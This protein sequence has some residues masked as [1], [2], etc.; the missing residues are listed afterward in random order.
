MGLI[1]HAVSAPAFIALSDLHRELVDGD[2][3]YFDYRMQVQN[4]EVALEDF[5]DADHP[6]N[7]D[8][9]LNA[10]GTAPDVDNAAFGPYQQPRLRLIEIPNYNTSESFDVPAYVVAHET[11]HQC[12]RQRVVPAP[13]FAFRLIAETMAQYSA[14]LTIERLHRPA[15]VRTLLRKEL[16]R[17]LH[18]RRGAG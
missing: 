11:G 18:S 17:Y 7:L 5:Y 1:Q 9:Q 8:D 4:G 16:D 2:R 3:H 10:I 6:F 13:R 14:L 15:A 12:W